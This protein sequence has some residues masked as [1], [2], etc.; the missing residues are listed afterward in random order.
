LDS[1]RNALWWAILY[2]KA[3]LINVSAVNLP[4]YV[5]SLKLRL[6]PAFIE[7]AFDTTRV[8]ANPIY[9][10]FMGRYPNIR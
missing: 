4:P 6:W 5:E 7:Y 8:V 3:R 9:H 10:E 2:A 1:R